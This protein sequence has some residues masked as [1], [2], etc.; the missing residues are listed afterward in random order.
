VLNDH[1]KVRKLRDTHLNMLV[2]YLRF[3]YKDQANAELAQ[4]LALFAMAKEVL[5]IR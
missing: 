5:E 4:G 1:A 3:K 2:R